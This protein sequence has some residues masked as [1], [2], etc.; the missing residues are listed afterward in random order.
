MDAGAVIGHI[1]GFKGDVHVVS[2]N[3]GCV[4]KVIVIHEL[5]HVIGFE[6]EHQRNDRDKHITVTNIQS[7]TYFIQ[8][9]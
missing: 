3:G 9:F 1:T 7:R 2:L 5:M 6:H 8:L 4:S